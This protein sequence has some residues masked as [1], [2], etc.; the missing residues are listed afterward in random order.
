MVFCSKCGSQLNEGDKACGNCG[1]PVGGAR[2]SETS[3]SNDM[4]MGILAYL[5]ILALIP[6][7]VKD[8]TPF[9]RAH[10]VRGINL[11]ILEVIAWVAVSVFAWVPVLDVILSTVVGLACFALS[12]IGIINVANKEDKDLPF[13]GTIRLIKG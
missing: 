4:W 11:L 6:Y 9:V 13:I 1:E 10:A 7:L 5:G 8:Q 12:L 3:S 2:Y